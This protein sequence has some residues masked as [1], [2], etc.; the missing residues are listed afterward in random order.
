[1]HHSIEL[2]L[3]DE[4]KPLVSHV[5][6]PQLTKWTQILDGFKEAGLAFKTVKPDD[7]VCAVEASDADEVKNPSRKMLSMWQ[8]AV[9]LN[10]HIS[11]TNC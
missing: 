6:N 1:V 11:F 9:S 4:S 10:E 2:S 5:A 3:N 8:A 7:W